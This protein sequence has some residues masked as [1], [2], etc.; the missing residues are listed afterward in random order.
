[1]A[2]DVDTLVVEHEQTFKDLFGRV[3]IDAITVCDMLVVF[4]VIRSCMVISYSRGGRVSGGFSFLGVED[5]SFD[6]FS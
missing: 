4:H 5:E 1:M 6:V 3:E 2:P